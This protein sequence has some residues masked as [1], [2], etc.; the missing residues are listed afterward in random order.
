MSWRCRKGN[1]VCRARWPVWTDSGTTPD[2]RWVTTKATKQQKLP[3]QVVP[4]PCVQLFCSAFP[5]F[6]RSVP[7]DPASGEESHACGWNLVP[8]RLRSRWEPIADRQESV[9]GFLQRDTP[10]WPCFDS[11]LASDPGVPVVVASSPSPLPASVRSLTHDIQSRGRRPIFGLHRPAQF[12]WKW[13]LRRWK[14]KWQCVSNVSSSAWLDQKKKTN[15]TKQWE[16]SLCHNYRPNGLFT[17]NY[18][19]LLSF[20]NILSD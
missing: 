14:I 9:H 6:P 4:L 10:A 3:P 15:P 1:R 17:P 19:W 12:Y 20:I 16:H 5:A 2:R 7:L 18:I 8:Q 13:Y 11:A